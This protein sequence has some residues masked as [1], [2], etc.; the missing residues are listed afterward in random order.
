MA[1]RPRRS[2]TRS[3]G[4]LRGRVRRRRVRLARLRAGRRGR[5]P[6]CQRAS[7]G[8]ERA[9][10]LGRRLAV[11]SA[12]GPAICKRIGGGRSHR[13]HQRGGDAPARRTP[14]RRSTPPR[15]TRFVVSRSMGSGGR[16]LL[17]RAR[18]RTWRWRSAGRPSRAAPCSRRSSS[19]RCSA[20]G[21]HGLRRVPAGATGRGR[22]RRRLSGGRLRVPHVP[23]PPR[24]PEIDGERGLDARRRR[25]AARRGRR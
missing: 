18:A 24:F 17:L 15:R 25:G 2:T 4:R 7:T 6:S 11:G 16:G 9:R 13:P 1:E 22:R 21:A 5:A 3:S 23:G 19:G 20:R 14:A 12:R 8:G 10:R